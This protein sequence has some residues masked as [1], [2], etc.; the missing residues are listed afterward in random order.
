MGAIV[1]LADNEV[2]RALVVAAHPDD[3]DFWAGGTVAGWTNAGIAVTCCVL[4]DPCSTSGG[5]VEGD[6]AVAGGDVQTRSSHDRRADGLAGRRAPS[7]GSGGDAEG[8]HL[9]CSRHVDGVLR[10][11]SP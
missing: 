6:E 7:H 1:V 9:A 4:S 8:P 3:A 10:D 2:E 11:N 5:S